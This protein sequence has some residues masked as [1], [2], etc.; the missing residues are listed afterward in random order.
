MADY[1]TGRQIKMDVER[2]S[3]PGGFRLQLPWVAEAA[4]TSI[5]I[6]SSCRFQTLDH[7]DS[8][9]ALLLDFIIVTDPL[10]HYRQEGNGT[11]DVL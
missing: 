2:G 1:F 6:F 9:R 11:A 3:S 4:Q 8:W 5:H 7:I 10:S